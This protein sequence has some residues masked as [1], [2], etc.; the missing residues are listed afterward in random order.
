MFLKESEWMCYPV[1]NFLL[2]VPIKISEPYKFKMSDDEEYWEFRVTPSPVWPAKKKQS[3]EGVALCPDHELFSEQILDKD[4]PEYKQFYQI[5][6]N[7]FDETEGNGKSDK[8]ENTRRGKLLPPSTREERKKAACEINIYKINLP[9]SNS[10]AIRFYSQR[11]YKSEGVDGHTLTRF[12]G[13]LIQDSHQQ[14][15][16]KNEQMWLS[17]QFEYGMGGYSTL[18]Y[19][20]LGEKTFVVLCA[21]GWENYDYEIDEIQNGEIEKMVDGGGNGV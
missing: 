3:D 19:F 18:G 9:G 10:F 11:I 6:L 20:H 1:Y 14:W 4:S 16:L 21:Y 5:L 13:W 17:D 15:E 8:V 12:I 7:K 2:K